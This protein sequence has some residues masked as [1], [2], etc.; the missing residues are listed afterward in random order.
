M[1]DKIRN[2]DCHNRNSQSNT[3]V[4]WNQT[5]CYFVHLRTLLLIEK[6][7]SSVVVLNPFILLLS[8]F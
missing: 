8:V 7:I 3:K 6:Y 4:D 1:G 5:L 2:K